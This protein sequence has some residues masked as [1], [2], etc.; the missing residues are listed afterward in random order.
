[1]LSSDLLRRIRRIQIRTNRLVTDVLAGQY[2]SAFKG[3]GMEFE[4]VRPYLVGDDVRTI[5]WNVSARLGDPHV[6]LFR[7]ERELTVILAVDLSGSLAFGS[8]TELKRELVAEIAGTLAFSAIR[9]NDKVAL[10]AFTDRIEL[11]VPPRKGPRHVLRIVRELMALEPR[12]TAT[13]LPAAIEELRRIFRRR[14]VMFLVS[15][16]LDEAWERPF[17]ALRQRH[18]LIPIVVEDERERRLPN[19]GLLELTDAEHGDRLL[20]DTS[21]RRMRRRFAALADA[22]RDLQVDTFRRLGADPIRI[23]TG[24]NFV[25]PIAAYFR[26]REG[27]RR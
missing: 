13:D 6:K 1:M 27:R 20:V 10:L 8:R 21:D 5:D 26:R 23:S 24:E 9:N 2:H 19:I 15:D 25:D 18:D 14:G 4:E 16:F 22:R 17:R 7:E 3:R 11:F 12:G